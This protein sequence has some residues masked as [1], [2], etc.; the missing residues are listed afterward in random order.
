MNRLH[1]VL[2]DPPNGELGRY[3]IRKPGK[4]QEVMKIIDFMMRMYRQ[5][6]ML[7]LLAQR[8]DAGCAL[9]GLPQPAMDCIILALRPP[10][11]SFANICGFPVN[12]GTH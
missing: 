10:I 2:P 6:V 12:C 11:C 8:F 1:P 7:L 3:S 5:Q 4:A 9:Y